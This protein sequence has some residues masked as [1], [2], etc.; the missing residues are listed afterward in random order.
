MSKTRVGGANGL[1]DLL[2]PLVGYRA[3]GTTTDKERVTALRA[4]DLCEKYLSQ[5]GA[6]KHLETRDSIYLEPDADTVEIPDGMDF[7]KDYTL[8]SP[9]GLGRVDVKPADQFTPNSA[10]AY[11][12]IGTTPLCAMLACDAADGKMKFWFNRANATL[13]EIAYPISFQRQVV[14]LT[15]GVAGPGTE[16]VLPEGYEITILLPCAEELIKSRRSDPSLVALSPRLQERVAA[17]Y[18]KYRSN[19][20]DTVTDSNLQRRKSETDVMQTVAR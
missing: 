18:D 12:S 15:D 5:G 11:D 8:W 20:K 6:Y 1:I 9:D 17:F 19:K 3:T 14:N 16:S 10:S 7:G 2:L 4:L 13:N